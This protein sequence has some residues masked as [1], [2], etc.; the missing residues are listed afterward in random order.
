MTEATAIAHPNIALAK[1]WGKRDSARNL[2]AVPSLSVTL[3]GMTTTTTVAFAEGQAHDTLE[4]DGE[5]TAGRALA[6]VSQLL[7]HVCC[8]EAGQPRPRAQVRS[9][10]DFPTAAG[11]ASSASAFAALAVAANQASG[12]GLSLARLSSIAR[13]VSASAGRSVFGGYVVLDS[14]DDPDLA[15][16]PLAPLDHWDLRLVVAVTSESKKEI[17]STEGMNHTAETSPLYRAWVDGSVAIFERVRA[18]VLERDFAALAGAAEQSALVMHATA[19]G[20]D[21][22]VIYWLPATIAVMRAVR[23]LRQAGTPAFFTIDAGPHVKV[24][25]EPEHE[26]AVAEALTRVEGV[27]RTIAARPGRGARIVT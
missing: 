22:G 25:T 4:L 11:L 20:A 6:R 13:Q 24:F 26:A 9:S 3:D 8:T 15:A 2:P 21:P 14:S 5:A 1:Y 12:A 23:Q 27:K 19:I 18:A 16:E 7:D 17:G 10:N